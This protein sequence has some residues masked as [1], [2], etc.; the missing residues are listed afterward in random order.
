MRIANA[1]TSDS[2]V[3]EAETS[4]EAAALLAAAELSQP[5]GIAM[6]GCY[7]TTNSLPVNPDRSTVVEG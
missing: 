4:R 7:P 3:I 2:F 5:M 1:V 6:S